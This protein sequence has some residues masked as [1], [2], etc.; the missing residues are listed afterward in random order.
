MEPK[1]FKLPVCVGDVTLNVARG[2]F[3]TSHSHINYF[4]DVTRQKASLN[5][6]SAVAQQLAER[7]LSGTMVDTILCLDGTRVIGTCLARQLTQS[8]FRSINEGRDI[9]ILRAEMDGNAKIIFRD[10]A[11]FMIEGKN[12]LILM[13][14]LTTGKTAARSMGEVW[15]RTWYRLTAQMPLRVEKKVYAQREQKRF[16]LIFGTHRI[17][18]YGNSSH[19]G[20]NYD[21]IATRT[22]LSFF[23]VPLPVTMAEEV[24][25][26]YT[27]SPA[28]RSPA[29]AQKDGE[30]LL[31]EYL[32]ALVEREGTVSSTLCSVRRQGDVLEVTLTAE[33]REQI[34]VSSPV[35]VDTKDSDGG[36][37]APSAK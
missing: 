18:L 15:A 25:R 19:S 4:I 17:N 16:A 37:G 3:A 14:S 8:G 11:R 21:K 34:G 7:S 26:P 27:V 5:E 24:C 13:A 6:A 12:V 30:A 29:E 10:N 36:A 9:Y 28:E 33:C 2:H 20:E 1:F 23:G 22:H 35:Y 31:K 32:A